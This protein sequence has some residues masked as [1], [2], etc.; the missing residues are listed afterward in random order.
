MKRP[1]F[2]GI[3][4]F[5]RFWAFWGS[6]LL[7]FFRDPTT[8]KIPKNPVWGS[9]EAVPAK[10]SG[11]LIV[12]C[13]DSGTDEPKQSGFWAVKPELC[14]K[15]RFARTPAVG[16]MGVWGQKDLETNAEIWPKITK[17]KKNRTYHQ[18]ER[19]F[20]RNR[21]A[22]FFFNFGPVL[23]HFWPFYWFWAVRPL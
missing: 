14:R 11:D 23:T 1:H 19:N 8:A 12:A 16:P 3:S 4:I 10:F 21:M 18:N 15:Y 13:G 6:G 7:C 22:T 9:V 20:V 17:N 5:L 2:G